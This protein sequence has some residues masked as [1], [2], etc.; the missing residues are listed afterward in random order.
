MDQKE[1]KEKSALVPRKPSLFRGELFRFGWLKYVRLP[2]QALRCRKPLCARVGTIPPL[3][4]RGTAAVMTV[5]AVLA[6]LGL[7]RLHTKPELG[8][9]VNTNPALMSEQSRIARLAA[10]T[11]PGQFIV[12]KASSEKAL[13]AAQEQ[14][15]ARLKDLQ[16][17][18]M[19][20]SFRSLSAWLPGSESQEKTFALVHA[21]NKRALQLL[22]SQLGEAIP[23]NAR[24]SF[25]PLTLS[26]L[27]SGFKTSVLQGTVFKDE[28]GTGLTTLTAFS[29]LTLQSI[30][31][32]QQAAETVPGAEFLNLTSAISD[33]L[34]TCKE[35]IQLV[36]A[37]ILAVLGG[38]FA[39][40]YRRL[41]WRLWLPCALTVVATQALVT[42]LGAPWS[43]FSVLPLVLLVGLAVDYAV[44]AES[45]GSSPWV[46]D[47]L[48][49][50]GC[51]TIAS[52]GLLAFS[53]TPALS[54]FGL[55]VTIGIAL[56]WSLTILLRKN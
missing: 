33:E 37:G 50:A 54:A 2:Q 56:A 52:F 9:L 3:S 47:S 25:A 48:I 29:D 7:A 36:L 28:S 30:P 45:E 42:L 19:I 11:T 31:E 1:R 10:P 24:D 49:L 21:A 6:A 8:L 53:A 16:S 35:Q 51:S 40:L 12:L 38:Y 4:P 5:I 20:G 23:S 27:S 34:K 14:L 22:S 15:G 43:L 32:L 46:W 55:T 39:L 26:D 13:L 18:G 17:K 44:I 41:W